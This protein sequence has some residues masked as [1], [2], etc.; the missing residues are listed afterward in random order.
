VGNIK[1]FIE[2]VDMYHDQMALRSRY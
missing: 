2:I 1:I